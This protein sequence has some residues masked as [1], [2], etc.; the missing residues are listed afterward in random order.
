M[1]MYPNEPSVTVTW[2]RRGI[3][4]TFDRVE[5]WEVT[6]SG[7]HR[8]V[9]TDQVVWHHPSVLPRGLALEVI[10]TMMLTPTFWQG[11][12]MKSERDNHE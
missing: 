4:R 6:G 3:T 12:N 7:F 9:G 10:R 8:R 5:K 2:H 1:Y 11:L